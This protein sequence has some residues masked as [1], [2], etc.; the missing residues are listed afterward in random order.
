MKIVRLISLISLV[1][2]TGAMI[3]IVAADFTTPESIIAA[4]K[5]YISGATYDPAVFFPGDKGTLTV[6]VT[7]GNTVT[8]IVVNHASLSSD[9]LRTTSRPYDSSSSLGPAQKQSFIFSVTAD[10]LDGTYFP[11]FS[12]SFRDADSLFYRAM[13]KIDDTPVELTILDKPDTF[14]QGKKKTIYAQVANP[15]ENTVKNVILEVSGT[16]ITATPS[17]VF[18][19]N[20]ASG[21]KVPVNFTVT[22]DQATTLNLVLNYDNGNNPHRVNMDVPIVFGTDK[23][24]ANPVISNVQAKNDAGIYHITG[25][26][27]NAGLETANT[28]MVTALSPAVPQDPYKTYVVGALKPDDFGSFEVTFSATNAESIP[29]Q[30]SYKDADGNV[31]TSLQDVKISTSGTGTPAA[32]TGLPVIPIVAAIVILAVFIGGWIVYLKKSKK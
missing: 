14:S 7:N 25:D 21:A 28:V 10:G 6:D 27:N 16:G 24:Q 13:V 12:L 29:L 3:G 19:G 17:R 4:D 18:V 20:V 1:L 11:T 5:V 22:A 8:G 26:V 23:K 9:T 15:R 30:L 2:L 31:Y 32:S